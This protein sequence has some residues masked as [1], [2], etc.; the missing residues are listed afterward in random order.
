MALVFLI[1][2]G[3]LGLVTAQCE[4][5][6]KRSIFAYMHG[7]LSHRIFNKCECAFIKCIPI[8]LSVEVADQSWPSFIYVPHNASVY[9]NCTTDSSN[10]FWSI[11]LAGDNV[12]SFLPFFPRG[13]DLNNEGLYDIG[14]VGGTV[15]P[16]LRLLINDT[17][18]N[19][20]TVIECVGRAVTHRTV[21]FLYGKYTV[22]LFC[23]VVTPS[24]ISVPES[25]LTNYINFKN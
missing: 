13:E 2:G 24:I 20:Q 14:V 22:S 1:T 9:I 10:P 8:S 3:L 19:N 5:K 17:E 21:I 16:T 11:N 25:S 6:Y 15:P 18:V 12:D 4:G 23:D 7:V